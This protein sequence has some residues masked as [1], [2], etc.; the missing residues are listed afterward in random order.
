MSLITDEN[1][2]VCKRKLEIQLHGKLM[3]DERIYGN[4]SDGMTNRFWKTSFPDWQLYYVRTMAFEVKYRSKYGRIVYAMYICW[5]KHDYLYWTSDKYFMLF[6]YAL[7]YFRPL[8]RKQG[9]DCIFVTITMLEYIDFK[10]LWVSLLSIFTI[11][12]KILALK[13][14]K[15]EEKLKFLK[16]D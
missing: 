11:P 15:Q 5:E 12:S 9:N 2:H 6:Q 16:Y 3:Q 7:C 14:S 8:A 4:M 10:L 1:R 13:L